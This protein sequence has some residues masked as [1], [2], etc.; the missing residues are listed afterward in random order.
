VAAA[1]DLDAAVCAAEEVRAAAVRGERGGGGQCPPREGGER[2]AAAEDTNVYMV[3]FVN[4]E[5]GN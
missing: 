2:G 5:G 1:L 4:R 3:R